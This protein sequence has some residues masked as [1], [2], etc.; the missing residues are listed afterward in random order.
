METGQL[1]RVKYGS[2]EKHVL[3]VVRDECH[4]F[5]IGL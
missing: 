1:E 3:K 4:F 2:A 5:H